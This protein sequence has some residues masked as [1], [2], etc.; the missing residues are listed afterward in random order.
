[1]ARVVVHHRL[2][3]DRA[4]PAFARVGPR[5]AW[6]VGAVTVEPLQE[7]VVDRRVVVKPVLFQRLKPT[8][9]TGLPGDRVY[10]ES[11]FT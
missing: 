10:L 2:L 11:R 7:Q 5:L 1:M 8:G 3:R 4:R 6:Q 9:D